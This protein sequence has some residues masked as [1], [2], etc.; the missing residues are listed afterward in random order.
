MMALDYPSTRARS[1]TIPAIDM[2]DNV[3]TAFVIRQGANSFAE[4]STGNNAEEI[5]FKRITRREATVVTTAASVH[6]LVYGTA[7]T[8]E[9]KLVTE[10]VLVSFGSAGQA[11]KLPDPTGRSGME[12]AIYNTSGNAG[13]VQTN[14][15]STLI[16]SLLPGKMCF[17]S[18]NGVGW[19]GG[20]AS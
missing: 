12:L 13:V 5:V 9:T 4:F 17:A 20:S 7:G 14:S 16:A 11:V 6:T 3:G 8:N 19:A 18:T 10:L 1:S 15:G 2:P